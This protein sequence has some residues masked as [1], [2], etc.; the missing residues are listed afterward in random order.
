MQ[1]ATFYGGR[2]IRLEDMPQPAPGPGEVLCKTTPYYL[3]AV[4]AAAG[5]KYNIRSEPNTW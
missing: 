3:E 5:E 1:A 2:D 4:G